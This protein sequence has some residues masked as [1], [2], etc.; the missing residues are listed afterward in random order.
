MTRPI[1]LVTGASSGI[2]LDLAHV[3]AENGHDVVL[4]ARTVTKLNEVASELSK[5]GAT[6]HVIA[7]DLTRPNAAVDLVNEVKRRSLDIDVLV[8]NA[9][10]G[11]VGPFVETDMQREVDMVQLNVVAL[12]QL[13]KLLVAPMVMRNRGRVLNV[14]SLAGFLPGPYMAIYYATK[15]FVLSFSEALAEELKKSKVTVTALCPGPTRTQ[16]QDVAEMQGS[17]LFKLMP[18]LSSRRVAKIGYRAMM[19]GDR[20]VLSGFANKLTAQSLRI[21]P[22]RVVSALSGFLNLD[23]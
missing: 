17:R 13:T 18:T 12:I 14:A 11:L 10:F 5:L 20:V 4:V 19:S 21:S 23:K 6:A 2:G 3:L 8:N 7:S 22:R 15:A 16:F 9:G 1:A